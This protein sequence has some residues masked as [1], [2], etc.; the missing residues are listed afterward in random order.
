MYLMITNRTQALTWDN[1][2]KKKKDDTFGYY[3]RPENNAYGYES[4]YGIRSGTIWPAEL[5]VSRS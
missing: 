1:Q 2:F 4:V 3:K 5:S